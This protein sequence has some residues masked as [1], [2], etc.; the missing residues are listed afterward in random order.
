MPPH[1]SLSNQPWHTAARLPAPA[2]APR[3]FV[4]PPVPRLTGSWAPGVMRR[5]GRP[6]SGRPPTTHARARGQAAGTRCPS[7]G[8]PTLPGLFKGAKGSL[9]FTFKVGSMKV[10]SDLLRGGG[11]MCLGAAAVG[12]TPARAWSRGG[13]PPSRC[14]HH[15][16]GQGQSPLCICVWRKPARAGRCV[17]P[18]PGWGPGWR[19]RRSSFGRAHGAGRGVGWGRLGIGQAGSSLQP[20]PARPLPPPTHSR[21]ARQQG[22]HLVGARRAVRFAQLDGRVDGGLEVDARVQA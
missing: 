14:V 22:L 11:S 13:A 15:Q 6:R 1:A 7:P 21:R 18:R 4:P 9:S 10:G 8:A 3:L 12:G 17:T 16:E 19:P 2:N 20:A 5:V